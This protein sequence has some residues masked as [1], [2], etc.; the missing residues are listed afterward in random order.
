MIHEYFV[1]S[2]ISRKTAVLTSQVGLQL[3]DSSVKMG[4][5]IISVCIIV[6]CDVSLT[7]RIQTIDLHDDLDTILDSIEGTSPPKE[8]TGVP[9]TTT[10][11]DGKI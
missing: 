3:G 5:L 11:D 6:M 9:V 4:L 10:T 8:I 7:R 2:L 1:I